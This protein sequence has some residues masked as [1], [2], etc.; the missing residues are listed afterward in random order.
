MSHNQH[1]LPS[2]VPVIAEMGRMLADPAVPDTDKQ[3]A[4]AVLVQDHADLDEVETHAALWA[5]S[6][7]GHHD[8]ARAALLACANAWLTSAD[9]AQLF[10]DGYCVVAGT[11][12]TPD[13]SAA[14]AQLQ[15]LAMHDTDLATRLRGFTTAP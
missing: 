14:F 3:L 7:W 2:R 10:L 15:I 9:T 6:Q 13:A 4:I 5:I 11:Q 1:G 8:T 12:I